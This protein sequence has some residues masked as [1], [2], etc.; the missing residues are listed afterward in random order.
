MTYL[1]QKMRFMA[2]GIISTKG[3]ACQKSMQ[4]CKYFITMSRKSNAF[5]GCD[6]SKANTCR[7]L[8]SA[9]AIMPLR[10]G[11]PENHKPFYDHCTTTLI[12]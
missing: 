1:F 5:D 7:G 11:A 6:P 10:C 3:E 2:F 12:L 9:G 8:N 4:H